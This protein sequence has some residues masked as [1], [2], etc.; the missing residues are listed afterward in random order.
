MYIREVQ[1]G[2][3]EMK[4]WWKNKTKTYVYAPVA[5]SNQMYATQKTLLHQIL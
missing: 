4:Q 1:M 3:L 5:K 2:F